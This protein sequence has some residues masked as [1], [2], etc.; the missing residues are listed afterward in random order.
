MGRRS[1]NKR[2]RVSRRGGRRKAR[3]GGDRPPQL[4][5]TV[6]FHHRFRF[7]SETNT[8]TSTISRKNLLNLLQVATSAVT[9]VRIIEGIRLKRIAMW[10]NPVALGQVPQTVSVEWL[11]ENSP[12]TLVSDIGMGIKPPKVV[13]TPPPSSSNRWWSMSGNQ[14]ADDLFSLTYPPNTVIDVDVEVRMVEMEAPT[15]G[16]I[17]AGAVLGT[18]YGNLLDGIGGN[19]YPSGYTILP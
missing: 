17:P 1:K 15:A 2:P 11:G 7:Q 13:T 8:G 19:L 6:C 12:S 18:L 14:E 3:G 5:P 10:C 16:D 9:T 4:V